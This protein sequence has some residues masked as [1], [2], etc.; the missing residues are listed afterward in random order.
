MLNMIQER[1]FLSPQFLICTSC[2]LLL[3]LFSHVKL[4]TVYFDF[5]HLSRSPFDD[6]LLTTLS[7]FYGMH[8]FL[9]ILLLLDHF[10]L[11]R[12]TKILSYDCIFHLQENGAY[13]DIV[14]PVELVF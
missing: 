13:C 11:P 12:K 3:I 2:S 7:T 14:Y 4:S 9:R 10:L 8:A 5:L 1:E 6:I